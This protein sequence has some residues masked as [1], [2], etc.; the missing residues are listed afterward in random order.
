M[1]GIAGFQGRFDSEL[2]GQMADAMPHRGPDDVGEWHS[3]ESSV[4]LAHRRLSII[5]LSPLGHQPMTDA[6]GSAVIVFNGEI[7]NFREL[8]AQLESE[9]YGFRGHSDTEVLLALHRARGEA[10]LSLLNGI[11][12]FAIYDQ[13]EQKLFLACDTMGVKPLYSTRVAMALFSPAS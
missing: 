7:Y 13:A 2:L 8:R 6:S 11:F 3:P 5:D 10:M 12:A 4:G 9:G 1:C